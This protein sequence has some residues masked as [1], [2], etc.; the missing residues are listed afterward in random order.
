MCNLY[1]RRAKRGKWQKIRKRNGA[2]MFKQI[3]A[4]HDIRNVTVTRIAVA[5]F[6]CFLAL[7]GLEDSAISRIWSAILGCVA[8]LFN[9]IIP[10]YLS[11]HG[12]H[13]TS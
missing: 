3:H 7:V 9:P 8:V 11:F 10:I 2:A 1:S 5:G 13:G 6:A 12:R 4:L